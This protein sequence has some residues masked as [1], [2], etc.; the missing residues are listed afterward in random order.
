MNIMFLSEDV[1]K[2][3]DIQ[4]S[5]KVPLNSITFSN[6]LYT[7]DLVHM[8]CII[9]VW[10]LYYYHKSLPVLKTENSVFAKRECTLNNCYI[11]IKSYCENSQS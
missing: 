8:Y 7:V 10:L 6:A 4:F 11:L 1:I 2:Y 5:L 9:F 3:L